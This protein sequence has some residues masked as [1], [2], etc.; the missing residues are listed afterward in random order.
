MK[1]LLYSTTR[2]VASLVLGAIA[3]PILVLMAAFPRG[4]SRTLI[5]GVTPLINNRY[6][7]QAM[8]QSGWNSL[9]IMTH[10][11]AINAKEDFDL[12]FDN[13]IPSW[14]RWQN[15]RKLIAPYVVFGYLIRKAA[16]LNTSFH[17]G[18]LGQ[19]IFW[20]LEA[21]LLRLVG[22]KTL[23]MPY[24]GD[25]YMYS[26]MV[27]P[28]LRHGFLLSYPDGARRER[29]IRARVEYWVERAD[30]MMC[31]ILVDG[32][33]RWDVITPNYLAIDTDRWLP[34]QTYSDADG[35][36]AIVRVIHTPNHRGVKGTEF[37]LRSIEELRA[38]GLKIELVLPE[39]V[40][41]EQ[42]RQLMC[43]A[44]I[45]AEQFLFSMYALSGIE[46]M[47]T[48]LPVLANLESESYTRVFRRFAFLNECPVLSTTPETLTKN[49]RVL[50]TRPDLREQ[51][52]RA[53][54]LYVRKY[55]SYESAQYLFGSVFRKLLDGEDVDLMNLFNPLK[56]AYVKGKPIIS[57]P[58]IENKLPQM[59]LDN[60]DAPR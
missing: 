43:E 49:L 19:T 13:F 16:V 6:W 40:P 28:T 57:H 25:G 17:G 32:I 50:V 3:L 60:A 27:D 44:D 14:V 21:P 4:P 20:R 2:I 22:I 12:Y 35:R 24:G 48:G 52:G 59:Y 38:E 1:V 58:L 54:S 33:G 23:V 56:S 9:T 7:S 39:G 51:L 5:W 47:A 26:R 36:K 8:R 34:K 37:L 41:N 46:G 30:F 31:G 45:L 55:H 10:R 53:G 15:L 42:V 29:R 11:Y 18:P